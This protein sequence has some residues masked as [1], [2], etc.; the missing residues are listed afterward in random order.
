ME[1][2]LARLSG[3]DHLDVSDAADLL[4]FLQ[5]QTEPLLSH[6]ASPTVATCTAGATINRLSSQ[7]E[8]VHSGQARSVI[9]PHPQSS[10][11]AGRSTIE[12]SCMRG[13]ISTNNNYCLHALLVVALS[14]SHTAESD[15]LKH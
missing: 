12:D 2:L 13:E 3:K 9:R 4:Q 14:P 11:V 5:N 8:I 6:H 10:D 1:P 7:A 15:A